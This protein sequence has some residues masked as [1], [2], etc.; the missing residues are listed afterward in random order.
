VIAKSSTWFV[1]Y[2]LILAGVIFI[3]LAAR[4]MLLAS[5]TVSFHSDEAIVGLMARHVLQGERPT[6]FYGQS[7]MG[8][9]DAWLIAIGFRLLGE[10]VTTIR[11]VESI[12][13]LMIV[14]SGF[15]VAWR[16][17][18]RPLIAAVTGLL[19]AVPTPNVALYTTA[20][21]GGYNE[22][23]L[24]GSWMLLLAYD[25]TADYPDS[26][27]RWLLLGLCAGVGWWTNGLIMV[28][29]LPIAILIVYTR[30]RGRMVRRTLPV[31]ALALVAFFV[32]SAPWWI[33]DFSHNHSAFAIGLPYIPPFERALGLLVI[34]IP[35]LVGMRFPWSS[36]YFIPL[37]GIVV[38]FL[39]SAA[40]YRL[41]RGHCRFNYG[42]RALTLGM[43]GLFCLL[44]T[45]TSFGADPT[46]R[47]FLPLSLPLALVLGALVDGLRP[48]NEA[49][50]PLRAWLPLSLVGLVIG[51]QA[52]GQISA[53]ATPPGFTTQFYSAS[54]IPNDH[55]AELI[56]FLESHSLYNG[57]TN[58]WVAFRLA[59]LSGE[60][61][62]YSSA[63]PYKTDLSYDPGNNRYTPY[64]DAADHAERVAY[65]T[66]NFP[67]L[68][69]LLQSAFAAQ[70]LTYRQSQIGL[71]KVY[72]D[73]QPGRPSQENVAAR[74]FRTG[75]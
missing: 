10:S 51:Y 53:A 17:T 38:I 68:D 66:A 27:S 54:H 50:N 11:I 48:E 58:Y 56:T 67:E 75:S 60:R 59:F 33:Y 43:L 71:F 72:Y 21:L 65:I 6:F 47:Y 73:F 34:G 16:F 74:L 12:L 32:G 5:G 64:H 70:A 7:Y 29:A 28:Y 13:F 42:A 69:T 4:L 44:F 36:D 14:A 46:G 52:V 18:G 63:L 15:L 49:G 62:Q 1:P 41:L 8:S 39:Y 19:L 22:I 26:W 25:V 57:Y 9:L 55:D 3:A 24:L 20:T 37:V 40:I 61:L 23:L 45:A 30:I 2:W 35:G 31:L